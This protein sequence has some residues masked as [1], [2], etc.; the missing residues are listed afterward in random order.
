MRGALDS[1]ASDYGHPV[2]DTRPPP[3]TPLPRHCR[4]YTPAPPR[5]SSVIVE[6]SAHC[7]LFLFCGPAFYSALVT[8]LL[9][10]FSLL[11][12]LSPAPLCRSCSVTWLSLRPLDGPKAPKT[13]QRESCVAV[14][15]RCFW[16]ACPF[17][18]FV[19]F[20]CCLLSFFLFSCFSVFAALSF[21]GAARLGL[22]LPLL[23]LRLVSSL[24]GCLLF[25]LVAFVCFAFRF[26]SYRHTQPHTRTYT[27]MDS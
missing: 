4:S 25:G 12:M 5:S 7:F 11:L 19:F 23:L 27:P 13:S 18:L 3:P 22:P 24:L 1:R 26:A 9:F 10:R 2:P 21:V 17:C 15:Y 6:S 20:L 16:A 14:V 8:A